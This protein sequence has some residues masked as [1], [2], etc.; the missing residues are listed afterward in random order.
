MGAGDIRSDDAGMSN[1]NGRE[2][3]PH[4]KPKVSYAMEIIV[5]LVES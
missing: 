5:G 1:D 4:R 3:R 2:I